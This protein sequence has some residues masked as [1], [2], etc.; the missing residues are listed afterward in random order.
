MKK[1]T[2][3]DIA[4]HFKVSASTVSKAI[5]DSYEISEKLKAKIQAYAKD[6]NYKPNKVALS[7]LNKST[8]TIGVVLP[9]IL[10]Y[11]FAQVCYGIE[12]VADEKGYSLITCISDESYK[13]EVKTLEFL[14]AG[15]VDG[16]IISMTEETQHKNHIAHFNDIMD[17]KI[18]MVLFDRVLDAISCD[19][20]IVDDF[21]AAFEATKHLLKIGCKT[22]VILSPLHD[23]SVGKLRLKGYQKALENHD[24][25]LDESLILRL[26]NED[27]LEDSLS[28]L[29][30]KK[31][32]DGVLALDE[33]TAVK[34]LKVLKENRLKVPEDV[35]IIGF[36]NG[37]LSRYASPTLTSISQHGKLIGETAAKLLIDK[38]EK[39]VAFEVHTTK[40][41]KTDLI[42]R[43]STKS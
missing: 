30:N 25:L 3:K 27:S 40:I 16:L 11:F 41:I 1:L 37:R 31:K 4:L 10:S 14:S 12:R 18:P 8:K 23:S 43:E 28:N 22:I 13:K 20:V 9:N 17:N 5:N 26:K 38:I 42:L 19:K 2:I 39:K 36:S 7:L 34:A 6:N 35:S 29:L 21:E 32:I 33:L 24:I 15:T